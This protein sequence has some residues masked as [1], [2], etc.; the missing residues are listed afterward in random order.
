MYLRFVYAR[1][2]EGLGAREGFF[3]AAAE[4]AN[5]PLTDTLV[6][7]Q[8]DE[9]RAWFSDNLQRPERFSRSSSKDRDHKETKGLSWFKPSATDHIAKAFELK[10][11]LGSYGWAID[12]L[13]ESRIGYVVYEDDVQVVAEPF[14]ETA[15]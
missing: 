15:R 2:V 8:I 6:V 13:K 7:D 14:A 9:L 12:V 11:I 1:R 4:V 5:N 10:G 3:Q